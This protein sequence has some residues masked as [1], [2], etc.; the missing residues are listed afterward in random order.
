MASIK[1]DINT[2]SAYS[3]IPSD[4]VDIVNKNAVQISGTSSNVIQLG[5]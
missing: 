3:V 2:T 5:S 1:L 4:T